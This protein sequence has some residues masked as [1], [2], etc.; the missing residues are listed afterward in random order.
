MVQFAEDGSGSWS[1]PPTL[2]PGEESLVLVTHDESTFNANDGKRQKD[3]KQLL[4]PK[5]RGKGIMVSASLTPGGPLR[6]PDRISDMELLK[7]TAW[8]RDKDN[9]PVRSAIQFLEYSKDNYWTG[10]KMVDHIPFKLRF[11]YLKGPSRLCCPLCFR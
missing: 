2:A 5:G 10:D 9:K 3:G 7:D 8:P 11:R 4:R 6:V 1:P